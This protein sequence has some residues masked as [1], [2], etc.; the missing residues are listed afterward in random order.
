MRS[1]GAVYAYPRH[2]RA[3]GK[4]GV[5]ARGAIP[6]AVSRRKGIGAA[7]QAPFRQV[8]P[9]LAWATDRLRRPTG[10]KNDRSGRVW[11][12]LP[13]NPIRER[14]SAFQVSHLICQLAPSY[15]GCDELVATH[16]Q[17][18]C[19]DVG[20][21]SGASA[22]SSRI[23]YLNGGSSKERSLR[24]WRRCPSWRST[25]MASIPIIRCWVCMGLQVSPRL[26]R[27]QVIEC[28]GEI[29]AHRDPR[30]IEQYPPK[31]IL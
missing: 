17:V 29:S 21:V 4:R 5:S 27:H 15:A 14:V 1:S 19:A 24:E 3:L 7:I 20:A 16:S 9:P 11:G 13:E 30:L 26:Q 10:G 8:A 31:S 23:N 6:A 2:A 22:F 12:R 28:N 18:S 25:P